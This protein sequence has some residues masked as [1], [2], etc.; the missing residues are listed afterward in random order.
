M[1]KRVTCWSLR[2]GVD[3]DDMWKFWTGPHA[4]IAKKVFGNRMKK[5]T[6]S[7]VIKTLRGEPKFWGVVELWFENEKEMNECFKDLNSYKVPEGTKI[8]D[9]FFYRAL[10]NLDALK[11]IEGIPMNEDFLAR[12]TGGFTVL[13]E[14]IVHKEG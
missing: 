10:E 3:P 7:R 11:N 14:E 1:I 12:V 5:Y 9:D 8:T 4:A 6:T 13:V 2:E